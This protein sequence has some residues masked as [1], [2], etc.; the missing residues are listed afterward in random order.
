MRVTS[1]IRTILDTAEAGVGPEQVEMA[2][3]EAIKRGIATKRRLDEAATG[4]PRRVALLIHSVLD[5]T[6]A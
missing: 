2:I 4:R 1:P 6:A 5:R 3:D